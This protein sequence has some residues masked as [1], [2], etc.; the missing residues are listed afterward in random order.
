MKK[1]LLNLA[2]G[3]S[4]ITGTAQVAEAQAVE[5]GDMI[6]TAQY[7]FPN[8]W[9][10]L[11]KSAYNNSNTYYD[12]T[13]KGFGP[14]GAQFEFMVTD[15]ISLGVKSNYSG[16]SI[17]Y[18]EGQPVYD[19]NGYQTGTTIYNYKL[20]FN[21]VRAL[22]RMAIHFGNSDKFDAYFGIA[23]GY[24]SFSIKYSSNDPSY[25]GNTA[26]KNPIPI[27]FRL[28]VGGTYYFIPKLG[29]NF[30]IGLGGGPLINAGIATKF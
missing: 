27:G 23:A 9:N 19:A 11:V 20:S 18:N 22:G 28:D 16:T 14:I 7:G 21:R 1:K 17:S 15:K 29:L 4:L 3:L 30:E 2:L 12:F 5:Q 26:F 10:L 13:I 8:L 24:S 6:T 25:T